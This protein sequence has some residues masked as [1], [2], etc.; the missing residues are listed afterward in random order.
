MPIVAE[1]RFEVTLFHRG[2][3]SS[4]GPIETFEHRVVP[5]VISIHVGLSRVQA[6]N[7]G[8]FGAAIGIMEFGRENFGTD[9]G[10]WPATQHGRVAWWVIAA[11]VIKGDMRGCAIIHAW[12]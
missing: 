11:Q 5:G 4:V 6:T 10:R 2:G 8:P 1:Q 7:Q 12:A 9:P 3:G